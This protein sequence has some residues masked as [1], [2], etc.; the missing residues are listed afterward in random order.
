MKVGDMIW[1]ASLDQ[2][3]MVVEISDVK[4]HCTILYSDGIVTP[5]VRRNEVEVINESR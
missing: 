2:Y 5:G 3:G 4:K 1:D